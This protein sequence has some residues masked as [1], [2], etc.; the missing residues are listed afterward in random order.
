[1]V[2]RTRISPEDLLLQSMIRMWI[3]PDYHEPR[4]E[5]SGHNEH[6][7]IANVVVLVYLN[8]SYQDRDEIV[9]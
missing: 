8:P 5:R 4:R 1:M 9:Y 7:G 3:D 2:Q 6:L